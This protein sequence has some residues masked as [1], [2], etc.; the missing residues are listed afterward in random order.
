MSLFSTESFVKVRPGE[1]DGFLP[2]HAWKLLSHPSKEI[3]LLTLHPGSG[4]DAI[5]FSIQTAPLFEAPDYQ[6][7][8]YTWGDP[9]ARVS[10]YLIDNIH[11]KSD[12][13]VHEIRVTQNLKWALQDLRSTR[14]KITLWIDA[15]CINQSD[16]KE[17]TQQI[18]VMGL[19]YRKATSVCVWLGPDN[20][21]ID[22]AI[23]L[24]E[25]A[26]RG[27]ASGGTGSQVH[28]DNTHK[29]GEV[30]WEALTEFFSRSWW[31][32]IWVVQEVMYAKT[33]TLI[34]DFMQL[35][36]HKRQYYKDPNDFLRPGA[37][38][39]MA[40]K[41]I[42]HIPRLP[43]EKLLW[44]F[45][46]RQATDVRD[47]IYALIDLAKKPVPLQPDYNLSV[48][49]VYCQLAKTLM[50]KYIPADILAITHNESTPK[51]KELPS[52]TP[53]WAAHNN[54]VSLS[55]AVSPL[56]DDTPNFHA[57][58]GITRS[59]VWEQCGPLRSFVKG[60]LAASADRDEP[61]HAL[62]M[63]GT[64]IG[65]IDVLGL[66]RESTHTQTENSYLYQASP[67]RGM[68]QRSTFPSKHVLQSWKSLISDHATY[69]PTG[70]AS[71]DAFWATISVKE[72]DTSQ[73]TTKSEIRTKFMTWCND[74]EEEEDV[75][76]NE[77]GVIF[78]LDVTKAPE[79]STPVD[80]TAV[81]A[82]FTPLL[83]SLMAELRGWRFALTS[84]TYYCLVPN[85]THEKDIICV[86]FGSST[87]F[88]LRPILEHA[89]PSP[90]NI[91]SLD[92]GRQYELIGRCYV[93]GF[94]NGE[95]MEMLESVLDQV[96]DI[97]QEQGM[98]AAR[99]AV[100]SEVYSFTLI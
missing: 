41:T 65:G 37:G 16:Q 56:Q 72:P 83:S 63:R 100:D 64:L 62:T 89:T 1:N 98:A 18:Q 45:R 34:C 46:Y 97:Y 48:K 40:N 19:I 33:V 10:I 77:N 42:D 6:A 3:R 23:W 61:L 43:L 68:P 52:W 75:S 5:L 2:A 9:L 44:M 69:E 95:A 35:E 31:S 70:E 92:N 55:K 96:Q 85:I 88:V 66:D 71:D 58:D 12:L 91:P 38:S 81:E 93:H 59:A 39:T 26:I 13:L 78:Q 24:F 47:K 82:P 22:L 49:E 84:Q 87:P 67:S 11:A 27:R 76:I 4:D 28:G 8:S 32:R 51:L 25:Q 20:N 57:D 74:L 99:G 29:L 53:D 60:R 36:Q 14:S 94:M 17:R 73:Y 30:D 7:L 21:K 86:P 50:R 15:L 79:E 54:T 90:M 80:S